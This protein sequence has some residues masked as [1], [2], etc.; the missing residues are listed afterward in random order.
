M[1]R[2]IL[3]EEGV[4]CAAPL[5]KKQFIQGVPKGAEPPLGE[6]KQKMD[7]KNIISLV[8]ETRGI[9]MEKRGHVHPSEKGFADFVTEVDTGVQE[10]LKARLAERYP[11]IQFLGEEG[12]KHG[13]DYNKPVWVLDPIDGTTNLIYDFAMSA[14]SLALYDKKRGVMGVVYN[15]FHDELFWAERGAGAY[16][17]G[18]KISVSPAKTLHESLIGIGTTPYEKDLAEE[19]FKIFLRVY[20]KSLD[21]R[22]TGSAAIDLCYVACGRLDGYFERNLKPWD[23][24]AG[25]VILKEAGGK[26]T[27]FDGTEPDISKNCCVAA[28]NG[29]IH[30]EL[31]ADIN[32]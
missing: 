15:P 30:N 2:N 21:V 8:K 10:F 7:I 20:K 31:L 26:I 24:G 29:L 28:S 23:Y 19:N 25:A 14:V 32:A 3:S 22:R 5:Q 9:I 27:S 11:D 18:R 1:Q 16:F 13:I 17:N 12:E 4:I 6:R